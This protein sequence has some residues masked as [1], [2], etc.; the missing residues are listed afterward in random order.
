V[1][2]RADGSVCIDPLNPL[3]IGTQNTEGFQMTPLNMI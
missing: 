3:C 1:K 2:A